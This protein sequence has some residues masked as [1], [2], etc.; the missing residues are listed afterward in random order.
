VYVGGGFGN[1]GGV[2]RNNLAAVKGRNGKVT[3]FNSAGLR[4]DGPVFALEVLGTQG[5]FGGQVVKLGGPTRQVV[6]KVDGTNG[7]DLGWVPNRTLGGGG[8]L[9]L[10][11]EASSSEVYVG[12]AFTSIGGQV[13]THLAKLSATTGNAVSGFVP[14]PDD[15]VFLLVR[16]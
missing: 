7:G 9:I 2:S 15:A 16:S 13:R 6:D 5:Y 10:A 8:G 1:I 12:G 11:I 4:T 14:D 3:H